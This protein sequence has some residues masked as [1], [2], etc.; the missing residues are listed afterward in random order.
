[1][2]VTSCCPAPK[3]GV[4][5]SKPW[6]K[7]CIIVALQR[8]VI[9]CPIAERSQRY[10][11]ENMYIVSLKPSEIETHWFESITCSFDRILSASAAFCWKLY[12][13]IEDDRM[14]SCWLRIIL[15]GNPP[16]GWKPRISTSKCRNPGTI[17]EIGGV[18]L[19][20]AAGHDSE[21]FK[22]AGGE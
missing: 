16:C 17:Y 3:H 12:Q 9:Y 22:R 11:H 15:F 4:G 14:N 2:K 1:M 10:T 6:H 18:S 19:G 7:Y 8:E 21:A 13:V 20:A 5:I